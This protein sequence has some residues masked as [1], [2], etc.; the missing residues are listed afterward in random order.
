MILHTA[1]SAA[2]ISVVFSFA[3]PRPPIYSFGRGH[4][5]RVWLHPPGLCC[6]YLTSGLTVSALINCL[7]PKAD[8]TQRRM[9][10]SN[11]SKLGDLS[12]SLHLGPWNSYVLNLACLNPCLGA[13]ST[14]KAIGVR[15]SKLVK[16]WN[17]RDQGC[18]E[19]LSR[20]LIFNTQSSS[21][22]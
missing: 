4:F 13:Y 21:Y 6:S 15:I 2:Y 14:T 7:L 8:V 18:P 3:L 9:A 17:T 1:T 10:R 5:P 22:G 20:L 19:H 16:S 12:Q 11:H